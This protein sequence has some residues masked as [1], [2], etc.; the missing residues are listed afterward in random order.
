MLYPLSYEG[1]AS[2]LPSVPGKYWSAG[3]G[4]LPRSERLCRICAACR[5]AAS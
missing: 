1:L 3:L 4:W 2:R 5:E